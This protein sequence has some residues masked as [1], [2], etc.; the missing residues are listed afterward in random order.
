ML[1]G[2][3]IPQLVRERHLSGTGQ[4][5]LVLDLAL[6]TPALFAACSGEPPVRRYEGPIDGWGGL[7]YV[8]DASLDRMTLALEQTKHPILDKVSRGVWTLQTT[9]T[10]PQEFPDWVNTKSFPFTIAKITRIHL[11]LFFGLLIYQKM[12]VILFRLQ[13]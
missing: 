10:K 3:W 7:K 11:L 8:S 9:K 13:A 6:Y 4:A 12:S 5:S 1:P 2:G